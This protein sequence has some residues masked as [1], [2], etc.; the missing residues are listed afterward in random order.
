MIT[1]SRSARR[2]VLALHLLCGVGWMGLDLALLALV[3]TGSTTDSGVEAAAAYT[4][5]GMVVPLLVPA[6][7][8]GMLITGVLLGLGT[9]YGLTQ[10]WWVFGK[11]ALGVVLTVLVFAALLPG[12]LGLPD[13]LA[14]TAQ[15]VRDAVGDE[16]VGLMFPP[17]VSFLALGAALAISLWKP[18]G[19]TPWARRR[20]ERS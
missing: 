17:V 4:T 19:R 10:W 16:A 18:W 1:L 5:I 8:I 12:V 3:V 11:F 13:D 7:A 6:L 9:K 2:A 14:G 20:L 15:Q